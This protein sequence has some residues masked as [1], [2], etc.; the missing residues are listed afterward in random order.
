MA[1]AVVAVEEEVADELIQKLVDE[2]NELVI[3][4]GLMKT[5]FLVQ[6]FERNIKNERFNTS[7][8]GLK[9]EQAS[10]VMAGKIMKQMEKGISSDRQSLIM[11]QIK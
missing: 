11:S 8:Q 1:A 10:F 4:N 2:S 6:S 7:S 3:G 9:K 5:S